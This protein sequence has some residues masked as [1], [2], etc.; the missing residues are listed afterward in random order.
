MMAAC[1]GL[2]IA[3][4]AS[5]P[6]QGAR[7]ETLRG[8]ARHLDE[9]A[10]GALEGAVDDARHGSSSE[11][12]FVASIRTFTRRA[13]DFHTLVSKNETPAADLSRRVNAMTADGRELTDRIRSAGALASTFDEWEAILDVLGRMRVLLDGGDVTVPA[14]HVVAPLS[15]KGLAEFRKLAHELEVSASRAH[16]NAKRELGRYADRGEQFL[17]ELKYFAAQSRDLRLR[18]G[19]GPVK[20][21]EIGPIVDHVLEDAR[22]ADRRMRDARVFTSVWDDS[23]RTIMILQRM[24]SLVRS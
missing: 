18:A 21:Q 22:Q 13:G 9:T 24:A 12:S 2:Y 4:A 16:A 17:G 15:G 11:A 3:A 7:H 20:P 23:G 5:A 10:R 1:L 14:A 19:A 6:I 8:L